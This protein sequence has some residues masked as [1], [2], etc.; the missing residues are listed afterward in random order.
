[1]KIII[2]FYI[3]R[4]FDGK[5]IEIKHTSINETEILE[6]AKKKAKE[7]YINSDEYEPV[8]FVIDEIEDLYLR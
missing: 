8:D 4:K 5:I 2:D 3:K 6:L 1:M 7:N